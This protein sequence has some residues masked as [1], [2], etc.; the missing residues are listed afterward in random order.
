M[1]PAHLILVESNWILVLEIPSNKLSEVNIF[2]RLLCSLSKAKTKN[3]KNVM[4]IL[5]E[6]TARSVESQI[7]ID[8]PDFFLKNC[9][10]Y[11]HS[12]LQL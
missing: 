6:M 2:I 10:S 11:Q 3:C 1:L 12:N 9:N 8:L 5:G 7:L 4:Q